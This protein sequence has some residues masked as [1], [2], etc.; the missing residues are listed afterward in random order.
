MGLDVNQIYF[1]FSL[2]KAGCDE[3]GLEAREGGHGLLRGR[4]RARPRGSRTLWG[5]PPVL[6]GQLGAR[7]AFSLTVAPTCFSEPGP[8]TDRQLQHQLGQRG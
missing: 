2:I 5:G 4:V 6:Q 7:G 1:F 8:L 3:S